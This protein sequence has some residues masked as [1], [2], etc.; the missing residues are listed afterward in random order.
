MDFCRGKMATKIPDLENITK[1]YEVPIF[2]VTG[3]PGLKAFKLMN[4][5]CCNR[6]FFCWEVG[7]L[8]RK[9]HGAYLDVR[10]TT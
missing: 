1:S 9:A 8:E 7:L 2:E 10:G 6:C 5:E 3:W 4:M